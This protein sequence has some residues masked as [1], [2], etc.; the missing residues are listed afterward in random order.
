MTEEQLLTEINESLSSGQPL[1]LTDKSIMI[2]A[3]IKIKQRDS[4]Q[5][6]GGTIIGDCHSIFS[7]GTN[8]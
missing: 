4:L 7:I 6:V 3:T 5:I 1:I 8:Q 2:K